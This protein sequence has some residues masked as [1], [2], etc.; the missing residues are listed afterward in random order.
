MSYVIVV[1]ALCA[2]IFSVGFLCGAVFGA[3]SAN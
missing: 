1:I 3:V 2:T